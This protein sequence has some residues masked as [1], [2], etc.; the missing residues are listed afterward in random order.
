MFATDSKLE[1][2]FAGTSLANRDVDELSDA[3]EIDRLEWITFKHTLLDVFGKEDTR[4][5]AA[6][7]EC[8][9]SEVVGSEGEEIRMFGDFVGCDCGKTG[10]VIFD[11]GKEMVC[12]PVKAAKKQ[13]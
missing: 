5:I 10:C 12:R 9:L 8:H 1:L 11:Q 4:I 13:P 6:V 2:G 7:S 3:I